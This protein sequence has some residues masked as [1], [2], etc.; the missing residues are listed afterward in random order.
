MNQWGRERKKSDTPP[1]YRFF[2]FGAA[3]VI[4]ALAVLSLGGVGSNGGGDSVLRR[5]E[6]AAAAFIV[7]A[8]AVPEKTEEPPGYLNGKW[9]LWEYI[10]DALA[11]AVRRK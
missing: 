10:G 2:A 4:F 11:S 1:G 8:D 3:F 6:A 9:N 7:G 5:E